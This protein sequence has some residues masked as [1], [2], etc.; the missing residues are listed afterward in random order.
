LAAKQLSDRRLVVPRMKVAPGLN[1][2]KQ[3]KLTDWLAT[4]GIKCCPLCG[5]GTLHARS[6]VSAPTFDVVTQSLERHA[7]L[8]AAVEC[9][10]CLHILLFDAVKV[11][12]MGPGA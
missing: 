12:L 1:P 3:K 4:N 5:Y 7:L 10:R 6:V 9:G 8:L 11:G 2:A